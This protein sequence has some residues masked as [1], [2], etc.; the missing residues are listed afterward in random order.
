MSDDARRIRAALTDP[1]RLCEALGLIPEGGRGRTWFV[2]G[3]DGLRIPCPWHSERTGSC[4]VRRGRDGTVQ[5]QCFGCDTSGDALSLVAQVRGLDLRTQFRDVLE[6][7]AQLGGVRGPEARGGASLP[8]R[9]VMPA[10]ARGDA[11][12]AARSSAPST[13]DE[14]AGDGGALDAVVAALRDLAPVAA[15]SPAMY[16]LHDRCIEHGAALGWIA[17]PDDAAALS[18]LAAQ[19]REAVGADA[20][21]RAGI[22]HRGSFGRMWRG[23]VCIP[24]EAPNGAVDNLQGRAMGGPR[25]GEPKYIGPR[26][27]AARWPWGSLDVAECA[28]DGSVVAIVEGAIDALSWEALA[29]A[30][31]VDGFALGI[32]GVSGA[33]RFSPGWTRLLRGRRVVVALDADDAGERARDELVALVATEA[34]RVEVRAPVEGKDWNDTLRAMRGAARAAKGAA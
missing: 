27:H 25:E 16:Y 28:G 26:E 8:P 32:P 15:S 9:R 19:V 14:P 12:A 5:V 31:G 29:R 30:A 23:R 2:D 4:S 3:R 21:D 34:A 7:A 18:R 17:L 13:P 20:L 24:W 22:G 6:H 11:S 10:R 1:H 33:S